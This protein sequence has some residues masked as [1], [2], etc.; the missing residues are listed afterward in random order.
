MAVAE[1]VAPAIT[2]PEKA[3]DPQ[4]IAAQVSGQIPD[5]VVSSSAQEIVVK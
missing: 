3:A 5:G 2:K 4:S 1:P